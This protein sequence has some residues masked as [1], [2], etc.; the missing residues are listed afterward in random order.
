MDA[1]PNGILTRDQKATIF[2]GLLLNIFFNTVFS[3]CTDNTTRPC[4]QGN[5]KIC[6]SNANEQCC[7]MVYL[8]TQNPNFGTF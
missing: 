2:S 5:P 7:Q 8:D 6:F 4:C 1:Y 3:T